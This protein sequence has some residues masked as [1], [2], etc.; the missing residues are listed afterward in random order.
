MNVANFDLTEATQQHDNL[1][2][3]ETDISVREEVE[4]G[5]EKVIERFGTVDGL[6]NNAGINI[7]RLLVDKKDPHGKYELSDPILTR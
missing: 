7:P 3:V 5:V 6:V 2:F 4:S 1:L